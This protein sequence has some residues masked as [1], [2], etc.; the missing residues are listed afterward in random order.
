MAEPK[1][2]IAESLR[3]DWEA[4]IVQSSGEEW[5]LREILG[6][7][8]P[9]LAVE[10]LSRVLGE[11]QEL[12]RYEDAIEAILGTLSPEHREQL[13]GVIPANLF[14]AELVRAVIGSC[15]DLYRRLLEQPDLKRLHLGV[16]AGHPESG[17]WAELAQ[18]A[19]AHGYAVDDVIKGAFGIFQSW[20]GNESD[21]WKGWAE[22]FE[23]L[24]SHDDERIRKVGAGGRDRAERLRD[25]ARAEERDEEVRGY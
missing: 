2:V 23:A 8:D 19:L 1:G 11:N 20:N 6:G 13:I 17:R 15:P 7:G 16:L 9:P 4:A 18:M 24:L 25:Q 5:S 14:P 3:E 10:W 22:A 21:M 12:W